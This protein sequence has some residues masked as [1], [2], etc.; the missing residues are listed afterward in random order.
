MDR[1]LVEAYGKINEAVGMKNRLMMGGGG[2]WIVLP[3][4]RQDFWKCIGCILLAVTYGDKG[5]K[6][7]SEIP[8]YFGNKAPNKL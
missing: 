8:T 5:R 4:R 1:F 2:K 6:L 3:F 7:W